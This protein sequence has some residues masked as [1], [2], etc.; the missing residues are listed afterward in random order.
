MAAATP[1]A[2]RAALNTKKNIKATIAIATIAVA[3]ALYEV[4]NHK[5]ASTP[6]PTLNRASNAA[7][8]GPVQRTITGPSAGDGRSAALS[9]TEKS[10]GIQPVPLSQALE[11]CLPQI[12]AKTMDEL[13]KALPTAWGPPVKKLQLWSNEHWIVDGQERRIR[14]EIASKESREPEEKAYS[15]DD[16]GL[17]DPMD[18]PPE[19]RERWRREGTLQF[20]SQALRLAFNEGKGL[21]YEEEQGRVT[22]TL[23]FI[24]DRAMQC[25]DNGC[26]CQ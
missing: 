7:S 15:L 14:R 12:K 23:L 19:E 2:Q 8:D 11:R 10:G 5:P 3:V 24:G 9:A 20:K 1:P 4:Y 18:A 16:E 17:P 13:V 22:K 25:E 21:E 6:D 26:V